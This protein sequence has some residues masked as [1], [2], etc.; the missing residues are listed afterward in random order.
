[1]LVAALLSTATPSWKV[2]N[3]HFSAVSIGQHSLRHS[4]TPLTELDAVGY[5]PLT[6]VSPRHRSLLQTHPP[7]GAGIAF[8]DAETGWTTF[9]D[10]S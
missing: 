8:Q 1:M 5:P 3:G 2:L 4:D 9:T 7:H 10:G 6:C